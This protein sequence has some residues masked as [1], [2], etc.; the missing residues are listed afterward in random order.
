M[1]NLHDFWVKTRT[2]A[3]FTGPSASNESKMAASAARRATWLASPASEAWT[4]GSNSHVALLFFWCFSMPEMDLDLSFCGRWGDVTHIWGMPRF[5][6]ASGRQGKAIKS[7]Q[8]PSL[9][10]KIVQWSMIPMFSQCLAENSKP[11][12]MVGHTQIQTWEVAK[13]NRISPVHLLPTALDLVL[14]HCPNQPNQ[15]QVALSSP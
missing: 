5:L 2:P 11:F 8:G 1:V 7:S 14:V 4:I 9:V 12:P 6:Q 3:I 10:Q 15:P 13:F